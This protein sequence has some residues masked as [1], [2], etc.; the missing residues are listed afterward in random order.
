LVVST[1]I[2]YKANQ[3]RHLN[4]IRK[5]GIEMAASQQIAIE[6]AQNSLRNW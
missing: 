4:A 1:G 5:N 6:F 3:R 2:G